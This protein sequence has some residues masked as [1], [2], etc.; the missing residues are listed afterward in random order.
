MGLESLAEHEQIS[1]AVLIKTLVTADGKV[2]KDEA[3]ELSL[4][5][6]YL[7]PEIFQRADTIALNDP[8]SLKRFLSTVERQDARDIIYDALLQLAKADG[9]QAEETAILNQVAE[10]WDIVVIEGHEPTV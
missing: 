6:R 9:I 3:L 7:S 8:E 4:V 1:L 10:A 2:T 5:V